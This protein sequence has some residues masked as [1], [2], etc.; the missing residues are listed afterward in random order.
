[1]VECMCFPTA[2][3]EESDNDTD[4]LAMCG[5]LPGTYHFLGPEIQPCGCQ[6]PPN[7]TQ[8]FKIV[9]L[10]N[11]GVSQKILLPNL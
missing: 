4:M 3:V 2:R 5:K 8:S 10:F 9:Y 1:M 6:D 7:S 11:E